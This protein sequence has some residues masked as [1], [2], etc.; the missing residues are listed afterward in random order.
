M[1][2]MGRVGRQLSSLWRASV[3][4]E[5]ATELDFHLEMTTRELM[6][7]GMTREAARAEALRRFGD[8]PTVNAECR[9]F[10]HERDRQRSRAEYFTELR[11][12]MLFAL[13]QLGR[14][15]LF[16][17]IAVGTLALGIGATA[18]VFSA[19]HAV[20]LRPLPFAE[21]GRAHV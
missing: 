21:I 5:V 3:E 12:D 19:L 7:L 18:A 8:M 10:G 6:E 17:A 11:Q 14:S 15:R 4:D 16:A 9:R 1:P 20:V 2:N 13:R